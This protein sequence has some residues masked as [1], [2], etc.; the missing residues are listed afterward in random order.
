MKKNKVFDKKKNIYIAIIAVALAILFIIFCLFFIKNKVNKWENKV[1]RG[2]SINGIDISG[3]TKDEAKKIV[4]DKLIGKISDKVLVIKSKGESVEIP[5]DEIKPEYKVEN[6]IDEALE[7]GKNK[8]LL[9]KFI[10]I[11]KGINKN[12]NIDFEYDEEIMSMYIEQLNE[13][14]EIPAKDA[15]INVDS[16]GVLEVIEEINGSE[17]D[18]GKSK[19]LISKQIKT[20]LEIGKSEIELPLKEKTAKVTQEVLAQIDT[21]I[22]TASTNFNTADINRTENLKIA[23]NN[24]NGTILLPGEEFSYNDVVG[25]RTVEKGF[26]EGA[27]FAGGEVVQSIGGGVCQISTTLYQAVTKAGILPTERYNH[28]MSVTYANPSED[29]TV[30]WGYLDYKFKNIYTNPVYIEGVITDGIVTFNVYGHNDDLDGYTYDL[31]GVLT[32]SINP[33]SKRI[34]DSSLPK[35][36]EIIEKRPSVGKSSKGYLIKYKQGQEIERKEISSDIYNSTQG[37]IRYGVGE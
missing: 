23:T 10:G 19:E 13:L 26:K 21:K 2:I 11:K 35:G 5:Y 9:N 37:I 29:A 27:S 17:I 16:D 30:A 14:I 7:S 18:F 8:N 33:G 31:I 22:A 4:S 15:S 32:G 6:A 34:N 36:T 25:E 12:I 1:Y 24:I 28:T 20:D 3:K